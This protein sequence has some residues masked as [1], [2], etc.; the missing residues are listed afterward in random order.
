MVEKY[1]SLSKMY[2]N[3]IEYLHMGGE[4]VDDCFYREKDVM[5]GDYSDPTLMGEHKITEER[6]WVADD[7]EVFYFVYFKSGGLIL[8]EEEYR[9]GLVEKGNGEDAE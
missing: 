1:I 8:S 5:E 4:I 3:G 6:T 7:G 9:A 2:E